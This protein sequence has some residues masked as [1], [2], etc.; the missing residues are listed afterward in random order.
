M[1]VL[2]LKVG[3]QHK[4]RAK[5]RVLAFVLGIVCSSAISFA[6]IHPSDVL[7][8]YSTDSS[9][10]QAIASYYQQV[11]P[12]VRLLGLT[13]M[14][15][16]EEIS[17]DDYLNII[18]PQVLSA[19]T[20]GTQV[21]VTTKGMPLRIDAGPNGVAFW[22]RYSSLE[23][24]LTRIDAIDSVAGMG[25]QF[26]QPADFGMPAVPANPYYQAT[27]AF[28]RSD[29]AWEGLRLAARLDGFSVGDVTGM[30]DRAQAA[31]VQPGQQE[32]VVDDDPSAAASP[33]DLMPE[34]DANVLDP[35][36]IAHIYD[37][38]DDAVTTAPRPVVGYVSHGVNDGPQGLHGRYVTDQLAFTLAPGAV[39]HSYE[40][41]NAF[42]FEDGEHRSGQALVGEWFE[43]GGTAAAGHV[44]EPSSGPSNVM[45]ED[46]FFEM[47]LEGFTFAEA[48]WSATRQV[49]YV[50]TFIGDPLMRWRQ[51]IA[52]DLNLDG[53]VTFEEAAQ[54]AA[55]IGMG[56]DPVPP[57]GDGTEYLDDGWCLG[58]FNDDGIVDQADATMAVSNIGAPMDGIAGD[59]DN[60][61]SVTFAEA[62][63][64][65]AGIG[66]Q[67][68][69]W[70]LGDWNH[71]GVIDAN[72]AAMAVANI[73]LSPGALP[74]DLDHDGAVSFGEAAAVV[75]NLD[76]TAAG[77]ADGDF[78]HDGIV[79]L[80][81]ARQAVNALPPAQQSLFL[82]MVPEPGSAVMLALA[83]LC[84]LRRRC[85]PRRMR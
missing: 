78:N 61:G 21:I 39:F 7:V 36:Q 73:G 37:N 19:L 48:A 67:H 24:E 5:T 31:F 68:A 64:V 28:D 55:S 13:G 57:A 32:I 16:D 83:G 82:S 12:E 75:A 18:R 71:D 9:D 63:E 56:V 27:Q 85:A 26:W 80:H 20:D 47:M 81:D 62:A 17:G 41:F 49:S 79:D 4:R 40:S 11:Y 84:M 30:I 77:W 58:D 52:G 44:E 35:H 38:T 70:S 14:S 2:R 46:H 69:G 29:P 15:A 65:A 10:G 25:D 72:E 23:S 1:N 76:R 43:V 33:V 8:L 50:N 45:N 66:E 60:D 3:E 34:L 42:S 53:T 54:V 74:G 6:S 51:G 22:K 59:L